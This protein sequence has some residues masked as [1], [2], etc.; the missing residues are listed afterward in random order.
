MRTT[1]LNIHSILR[2]RD[3]GGW[4]GIVGCIGCACKCIVRRHVL[5]MLACLTVTPFRRIPLRRN[6]NESL[7]CPCLARC[8][9]QRGEIRGEARIY[10]MVSTSHTHTFR[11]RCN[12][13][14]HDIRRAE[15]AACMHMCEYTIHMWWLDDTLDPSRARNPCVSI[16]MPH[17]CIPQTFVYAMRWR[18]LC[19]SAVGCMSFQRCLYVHMFTPPADAAPACTALTDKTLVVK[20]SAQCTM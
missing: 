6:N 2:R 4:S 10:E 20:L 19:V 7:P 11:V 14:S 12:M 15:A 16:H 18:L 8:C 1:E 3:C 17:K 9:W 13:F 5:E